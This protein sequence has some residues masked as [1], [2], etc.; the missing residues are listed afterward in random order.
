[1]PTI[2]CIET[3]TKLCSVAL[4][5]SDQT[6]AS[7]D[8][9]GEKHVHAE[10]VNVFIEAV[11]QEAGLAIGDLDAVAVGIGPGSYTGLRIGVSAAKGLCFALGIPIIGIGT[12]DTLAAAA[13][14]GD[15]PVGDRLWPMIDARRMEVFT[16]LVTREGTV[17]SATAPAVLDTNWANSHA[18]AT[19]FGDG[20]DK[21]IT[22]W[23]QV[24]GIN[25]VAGVRPWASAMR[26]IAEHRFRAR[27]F[28]DLAYL[29]PNYGKAANVTRSAKS[30]TP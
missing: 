12:L 20:A 16:Q 4:V 24:E 7:R 22:L 5:R 2:L 18:P 14:M 27:A 28:D 1:M 15:T 29:V 10:K 9:E 25:H 8:L 17:L 23:E 6:L 13:L 26:T 11:V 21:A 19:V 3:A 30:T